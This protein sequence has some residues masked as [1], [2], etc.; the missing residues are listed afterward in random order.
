ML[1]PATRDCAQAGAP[2]VIGSVPASELPKD[3]IAA[4]CWDPHTPG[5]VALAAGTSISIIDT[6]AMKCGA[7]CRAVRVRDARR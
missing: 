4:G 6:R 2:K 7:A 5:V 3:P 1:T